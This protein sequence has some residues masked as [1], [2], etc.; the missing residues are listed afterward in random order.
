[1][2]LVLQ[3]NQVVRIVETG[4]V[5]RVVFL[6]GGY[7]HIVEM[8]NGDQH[9]LGLHEIEVVVTETNYVEQEIFKD[10]SGEGK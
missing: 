10:G 4:Q 6:G 7:Y 2:P 1:M 8:N 5:G 3:R 9:N